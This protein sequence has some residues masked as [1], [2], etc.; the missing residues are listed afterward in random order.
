MRT[1]FVSLS[2]LVSLA[3]QAEACQPQVIDDVNA[4]LCSPAETRAYFAAAQG[5]LLND[6]KAYLASR[7]DAGCIQQPASAEIVYQAAGAHQS[8]L[9]VLITTKVSCQ[10]PA[11]ESNSFPVLVTL[12]TLP[13]SPVK[14]DPLYKR[15][16]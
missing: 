7:A 14:A 10:L 16:N 6:V 2:L 1:L 4:P 11:P 13:G 12:S 3:S 8:D 5:G 15:F 9:A